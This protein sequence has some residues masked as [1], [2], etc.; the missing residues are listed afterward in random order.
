M[1]PETK[2]ATETPA[3]ESAAE[4]KSFDDRLMESIQ[5]KLT[6]NGDAAESTTDDAVEQETGDQPAA[7]PKQETPAEQKK[8]AAPEPFTP[9]QM[10]DPAF[11]DKLDKDG[12]DRLNK[13]HPALYA[14]GK[15]VASARGKA[16]AA[17]RT[18]TTPPPEERSE[19][20][21]KVSPE[22][23]A[24]ILRSQSLDEDE[25]IAGA[26]EVARLTNRE[27]RARERE[28]QEAARQETSET[29][30][31]AYRIAATALPDIA[32]IA[33]ADLDKEVDSSPK[34]LRMVK[35]AMANPDREERIQLLADVMEDAGR[36]VIAKREAVVKASEDDKAK[37]KKAKDQERL[38]SNDRNPANHLVDT[39]SGTQTPRTGDKSFEKHGLAHIQSQLDKARAVGN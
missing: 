3:T 15:Q 30:T 21:P 12:W 10:G 16:N 23:K 14:M 24:A 18:Q 8:E 35:S 32:N 13:L 38:R 31:A 39:P 7:E 20:K 28:Q 6:A 27:E 22:M 26:V 11:F 4:P 36:A 34:L 37:E 17:L 29:Y 33:D 9:E 5:G 25:A 1:D 19:A 2:E